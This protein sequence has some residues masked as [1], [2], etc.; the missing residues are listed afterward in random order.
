MQMIMV[1]SKVGCA[2]QP[3]I[4]PSKPFCKT[5]TDVWGVGSFGESE[6]LFV[7]SAFENWDV[8]G[9]RLAKRFTKVKGGVQLNVRTCA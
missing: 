6:I 5:V 8:V 7:H 3:N 9:D 2:L 1:D 4:S